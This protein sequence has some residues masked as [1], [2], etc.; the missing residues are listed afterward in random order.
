MKRLLIPLVAAI[1]IFGPASV[2]AQATSTASELKTLVEQLRA[3]ISELEAQVLALSAEL[4]V[5]KVE[6]KVTR[7]LGRGTT[8]ED[9]K[10]LQQFLK[11]FP[12]IYPEGLATGY[13][14]PLTETAV[15]RFQ[16]RHGIENVGVFGPKT[17]FKVN[18]LIA[19]TPELAPTAPD[20]APSGTIPAQPI[21]LTGTT[22]VPAQPA[23][24][25]QKGC[26]ASGFFWYTVS[27]HSNPPRSETCPASYNYCAGP[28]ECSANGWYWCRNSC[29]GSSDSCLGLTFVPPAVPTPISTTTP[30]SASPTG[31]CL[32]RDIYTGVPVFSA[33]NVGTGYAKYAVSNVNA[34]AGLQTACT[35]SIYDQL[36][37]SYCGQNSNSVQRQVMTYNTGGGWQNLSCGAQ[38]CDS[39]SCPVSSTPAPATTQTSAPAPTTTTT[40]TATSTTTTST[41]TSVSAD[42]IS[43]TISNTQASNITENSAAL[44]WTTNEASDSLAQY[45]ANESYGQ[46]SQ[47]ASLITSHN[48]NLANLS[49]NTLYHYRVKSKDASG[50]EA[51][52]GDYTFTTLAPAAA[53]CSSVD[54]EDNP[55]VGSNITGN[56]SQ[57]SWLNGKGLDITGTP[58][59]TVWSTKM[60]GGA[61]QSGVVIGFAS[62]N[63]AEQDGGISD[64]EVLTVRFLNESAKTVSVTLASTP[65]SESIIN[66]KSS[67]VVMDAFNEAGALLG[68]VTKT[69]TGVTNSA[70]TPSAIGLSVSDATIKKITLKATSHPYGGAWVEK[71]DFGASCSIASHSLNPPLARSAASN[72][73][74]VLNALSQ[75]IENLKQLVR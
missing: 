3:K 31:V 45:G 32:L 42:T 26:V 75:I 55:S 33:P 63:F 47:D 36:L 24:T 23:T 9:V 68:S 57:T 49:V 64:D 60:S 61:G 66:N 27:C 48:L 7:T 56:A 39:I 10:K 38:G 35:N 29:Y 11:K 69:F 50:N 40:T 62:P 14:G 73:A 43:P 2:Q 4:E 58:A 37:Q 18:E 30:S 71:I 51:V 1:L 25:T 46:T 53:G 19:K 59:G 72:L 13:F 21:G 52:S 28:S 65:S 70:Y 8:G 15:K 67:T 12:D 34:I 6:L 54:F 5:A 20:V 17:L 41:T 74:N 44:S 16:E 22:T